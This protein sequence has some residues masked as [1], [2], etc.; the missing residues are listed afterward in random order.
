[1]STPSAYLG[2]AIAILFGTFGQ[3]ALKS[4]SF[5]APSL[6]SQFLN[7]MTISGLFLY[8]LSAIAYIVALNRIWS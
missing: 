2:L 8:G 1:M 7:P 4:A 3:I 6:L 5:G